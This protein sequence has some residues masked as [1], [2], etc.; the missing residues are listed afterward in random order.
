M[1]FAAVLLGF[2]SLNV[3]FRWQFQSQLDITV[4]VILLCPASPVFGLCR[5]ICPPGSSPAVVTAFV[6]AYQTNS[7]AVSHHLSTLLCLP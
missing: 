7:T 6:N 1:F 5:M 4:F 2:P 3:F